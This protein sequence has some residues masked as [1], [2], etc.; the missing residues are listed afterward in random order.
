MEVLAKIYCQGLG[1][2]QLYGGSDNDI[3]RKSVNTYDGEVGID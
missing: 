3:Q 2:D 1:N